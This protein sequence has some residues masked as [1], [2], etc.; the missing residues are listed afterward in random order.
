MNINNSIN[1]LAAV[2]SAVIQINNHQILI[3]GGL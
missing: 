1:Y 3:L 2:D